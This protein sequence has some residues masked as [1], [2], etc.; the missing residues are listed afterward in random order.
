ML[1]TTFAR[2][3]LMLRRRKQAGLPCDKYSPIFEFHYF[4]IFIYEKHKYIIHLKKKNQLQYVHDLV[5]EYYIV[6]DQT[7]VYT[8]NTNDNKKAAIVK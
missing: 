7:V 4:I 2:N 1:P 5:R 3:N 6:V 8:N